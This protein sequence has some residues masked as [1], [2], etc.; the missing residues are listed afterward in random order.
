MNTQAQLAH[1]P[2]WKLLPPRLKGGP[3]LLPATRHVEGQFLPDRRS[4]WAV[5]VVGAALATVAA[6]FAIPR[7][8]ILLAQAILPAFSEDSMAVWVRNSLVVPYALLIAFTFFPFFL[9]ICAWRMNIRPAASKHRLT[10]WPTVS[11]LIPAHNE[12]GI[13]LD[14]IRAAL[15]QDYPDFEVIVIDDG[16]TDRTSQLVATTPARLIRHIQNQG[17]AAALNTGLAE[18][19][20]EVIITCDADSYFDTGAVRHL[21]APLA[22]PRNGAVAGQIRLSRTQGAMRAFQ[23]LEYDYAQALFKCA[24]SAMGGSVLVAPGPI[25]AYRADVLRA[26]GGVPG[27]TLTEDVDLT[28]TVI[29]HGLRVAYEPRAIAYTDAPSTDAEFRRQRHRWIRGGLQSVRKH[30]TMIGS[31]SLGLVGLFWL[32]IWVL[33]Y[34]MQV[35]TLVAT[36]FTPLL[37]WSTGMPVGYLS[38]LVLCTLVGAGIDVAKILIGVLASDWHDLR[39]MIYVPMYIVYK[40]FRT[41]WISLEA[42]YLELRGAPRSWDG[43]ADSDETEIWS[44]PRSTSQYA[45][46]TIDFHEAETVDL[47]RAV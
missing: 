41:A 3:C 38:Y 7:A 24:H 18:A 45:S 44:N 2:A 46:P 14:T 32:P 16:S 20:G 21:V 23:V 37:V 26:V 35:L 42:C 34:L 17:K 19:R 25:S 31:R 33:N 12:E 9:A 40:T 4:L 39:F 15:G 36:I 13:V 29:R 5:L 27:E 47:V 8:T 11:I 10:R 22:D 43:G 6:G 30:Q 1:K 28:L